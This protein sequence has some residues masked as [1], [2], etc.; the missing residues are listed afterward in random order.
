MTPDQTLA[1]R[2]VRKEIVAMKFLM[3]EL[4]KNTQRGSMTPEKVGEAM[5][6]LT[7]MLQPSIDNLEALEGQG[8]K[9]LEKM[10]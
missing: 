3:G 8:I 5:A 2:K 1:I 4:I 9:L 6:T 10:D 7:R